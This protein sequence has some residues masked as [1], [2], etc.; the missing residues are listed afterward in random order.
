MTNEELLAEIRQARADFDAV[1]AGI[2]EGRR[3]EPMFEDGW[4]VKDVLV[5]IATWEKIAMGVVR[6]DGYPGGPPGESGTDGPEGGDQ[7]DAINAKVYADNRNR[8]LADVEA[9]AERTHTEMRDFIAA[10]PEGRLDERLAGDND[11]PLVGEI[12]SGNS[13]GHYA[14]HAEWI[15]DALAEQ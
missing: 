4:S 12:L 15:R 14:E 11:L 2:A 10:L 7:A 9:E 1:V 13:H 3:T 5:H 8:A 6:N